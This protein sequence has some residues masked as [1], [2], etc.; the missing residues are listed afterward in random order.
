MPRIYSN[1]TTGPHFVGGKW[2]KQ[3]D[4]HPLLFNLVGDVFTK[5]LK[6]VASQNLISGLLP[7]VILLGNAVIS[8]KSYNHARS[9]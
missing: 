7:N 8:K 6:K 2:L 3:G 9:I 1:N 5:I 4:P